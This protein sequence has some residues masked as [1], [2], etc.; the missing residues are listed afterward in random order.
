MRSQLLLTAILALAGGVLAPA[1]QNDPLLTKLD[2]GTVSGTLSAADVR[3][4]KGIPFAAPPVGDLRW[5]APKPVAHWEGVRQADKFGPTCMQ[6]NGNGSSE[7][8]LYLN[9]WTVAKSASEKR[10]VMVWI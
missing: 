4:Y 5:R 10:P 3:I 6:G 7:D 1:A 2:S 8:C 9:V